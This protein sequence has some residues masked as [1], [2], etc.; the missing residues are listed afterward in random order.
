MKPAAEARHCQPRWPCCRQDSPATPAAP[1]VSSTLRG[2]GEAGLATH[3]ARAE[4][5]VKAAGWGR[6][7][8]CEDGGMGK[9]GVSGLGLGRADGFECAEVEERDGEALYVLGL[10][11]RE[12]L[13]PPRRRC[14]AL[15]FAS[16]TQPAARHV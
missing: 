1:A 7:E 4:K 15:T 14:A 5:K 3:R 11:P 6:V 8:A 16:V 10:Q 13:P 12:V 9:W 2:G